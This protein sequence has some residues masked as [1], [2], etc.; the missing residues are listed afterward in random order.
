MLCEAI[1]GSCSKISL[2]CHNCWHRRS[3]KHH[4]IE[5]KLFFI[6]VT[7]SKKTSLNYY[8]WKWHEMSWFQ[9]FQC[10]IENGVF[11][12]LQLGTLALNLGGWFFAFSYLPCPA[13]TQM[14]GNFSPGRWTT[15]MDNEM[16][17]LCAGIPS[18]S[19]SGVKQA[20]NKCTNKKCNFY[21]SASLNEIIHFF[22]SSQN[23]KWEKTFL[24]RLR[25][26]LLFLLANWKKIDRFNILPGHG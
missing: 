23:N 24:Y 13:Q 18:N 16:F 20:A 17:V 8:I 3:H 14:N 10:C 15:W 5:S 11:V 6:T 25:G 2:C 26:F 4:T 19:Q 7:Q 21:K 1:R 12:L 22:Q 9:W